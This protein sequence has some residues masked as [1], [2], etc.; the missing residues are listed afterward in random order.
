MGTLDVIRRLTES[1]AS[2]GIRFSVKSQEGSGYLGLRVRDG[3]SLRVLERVWPDMGHSAF[4]RNQL[5]GGPVND[6]MGF[7]LSPANRGGDS[8]IGGLWWRDRAN[9]VDVTLDRVRESGKWILR[10]RIIPSGLMV[11][12]AHTRDREVKFSVWSKPN[13]KQE[14]VSTLNQ[15]FS[16]SEREGKYL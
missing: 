5:R 10:T 8:W 11:R 15:M 12:S 9:Q 6:S 3:G 16:D 4:L 1:L 14:V 13:L 2:D 7:S